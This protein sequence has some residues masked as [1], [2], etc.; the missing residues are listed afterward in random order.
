MITTTTEMCSPSFFL[1]R[2]FKHLRHLQAISMNWSSVSGNGQV[3]F[4]LR[5]SFL[6]KNYR[7]QYL[8]T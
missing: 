6:V 7:R 3:P 5:G 8:K 2:S 1:M 4:Y